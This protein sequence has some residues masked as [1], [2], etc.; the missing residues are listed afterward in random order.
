ML[1]SSNHKE[2]I[3]PN[4]EKWGNYDNRENKKIN[5]IKISQDIFYYLQYKFIMC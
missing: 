1:S 4:K 3:V 2:I 5:Y